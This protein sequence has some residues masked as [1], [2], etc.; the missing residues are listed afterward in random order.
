MQQYFGI[1]LMALVQKN[2]KDFIKIT[3]WK[4]YVAE[5][6]MIRSNVLTFV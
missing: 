5:T 2:N 3:L 1:T 6:N 4:L